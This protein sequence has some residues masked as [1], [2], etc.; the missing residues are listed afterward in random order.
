MSKKGGKTWNFYDGNGLQYM[1]VS[2]N[3]REYEKEHAFGVHKEC[4][5]LY[6]V[7][8]KGMP[9]LSKFLIM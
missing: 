8:S 9:R 2:D 6:N 5:F 1:Q 3:D 7:D 4:A